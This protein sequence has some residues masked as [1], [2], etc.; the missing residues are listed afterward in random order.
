MKRK[1]ELMIKLITKTLCLA[2]KKQIS[3]QITSYLWDCKKAD[4]GQ[5][6]ECHRVKPTEKKMIK[7][8]I[9]CPQIKG[10]KNF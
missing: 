7:M 4:P 6:Y 10:K 5:D 9:S 3:N 2:D 1:I 8:I